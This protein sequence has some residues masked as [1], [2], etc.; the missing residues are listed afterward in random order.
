MKHLAWRG[1]DADADY[2]PPDLRL[3]IV[4]ATAPSSGGLDRHHLLISGGPGFR[5]SARDRQRLSLLHRELVPMIGTVLA[6][7]ASISMYGLS[8]RRRQV[9]DL[10]IA[11]LP[12]KL[13]ADRMALRP[14]TVNEYLQS[15]Y[16]HFCVH[17]RSELMAYLL[18]RVPIA[19]G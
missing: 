10:A 2:L 1:I 5:P 12:E 17:T 14:S 19:R 16:L 13:I 9:L 15:I 18:R 7:P 11:G 6:T 4:Y 8:A 3:E